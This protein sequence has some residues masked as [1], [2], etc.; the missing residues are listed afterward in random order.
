MTRV[1]QHQVKRGRRHA[2]ERI[3]EMEL[4]N[5]D[6]PDHHDQMAQDRHGPARPAFERALPQL[7]RRA[8]AAD[9]V[10]FG[11]GRQGRRGVELVGWRC[12]ATG[13]VGPK[14]HRG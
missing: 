8:F 4:G 2:G 14:G 11:A 7:Q 9:L 1:R 5:E 10:G 6:Q 13:V 3:L 12:L